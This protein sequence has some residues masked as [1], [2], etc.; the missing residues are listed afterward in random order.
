MHIYIHDLAVRFNM[1]LP[2]EMGAQTIVMI[3]SQRIETFGCAPLTKHTL[4]V[5][6]V[7][8]LC[9]HA[10]VREW[11]MHVM[12]INIRYTLMITFFIIF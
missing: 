9:E 5:A 10:V 11:A 8:R 3:G 1:C 2:S 4:Q 6:H 12:M 7:V